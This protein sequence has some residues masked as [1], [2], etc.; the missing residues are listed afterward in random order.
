MRACTSDTNIADCAC[1]TVRI[2]LYFRRFG[3]NYY[4]IYGW[5][6]CQQTCDVLI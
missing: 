6:S 4:E 3:G 2:S 1:D 5:V